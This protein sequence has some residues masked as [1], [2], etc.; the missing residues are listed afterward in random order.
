M[1]TPSIAWSRLS[2]QTAGPA[3]RENLAGWWSRPV[4]PD[5]CP[6]CGTTPMTW[7]WRSKGCVPAGGRCRYLGPFSGEEGQ[8]DTRAPSSTAC[9]GATL[10]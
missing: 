4:Q 9:T 5:L 8:V 6:F 2:A 3:G 7:Q 10:E 1:S